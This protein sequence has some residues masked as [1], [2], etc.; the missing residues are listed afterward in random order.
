MPFF[1]AFAAAATAA[2][3]AFFSSATLFSAATS[4]VASTA[5]RFSTAS[6]C[7]VS[8]PRRVTI[9]SRSRSIFL[10]SASCFRRER[11]SSA[12]RPAGL[13]A[14]GA[15]WKSVL[16]LL[17][18]NAAAVVGVSDTASSSTAKGSAISS[19]LG[20]SASSLPVAF[21][22]TARVSALGATS[23]APPFASSPFAP[24][25]PA[26]FASSPVAIIA[27]VPEAAPF[28]PSPGG[29]SASPSI[30]GVSSPKAGLLATARPSTTAAAPAAIPTVHNFNVELRTENL[31]KH[32]VGLGSSRTLGGRL[33][34][35]AL[36]R[37]L[38]GQS[39][40]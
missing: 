33:H 12:R 8:C 3:F 29:A 32:E 16:V 34:Q 23:S 30:T 38:P 21:V 24:F 40:I 6:A 39:A 14:G 19:R 36:N 1:F 25:S 18:S 5:R 17:S 11:S 4:S 35:E 9:S 2:F 15:H 10:R 27:P 26:P 7:T 20:A 22:A 13:S 37:V 28:L 31:R